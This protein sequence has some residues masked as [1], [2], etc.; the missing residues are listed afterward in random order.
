MG[1][2]GEQRK[3]LDE[4]AARGSRGRVSRPSGRALA[5]VLRTAEECGRC[6]MNRPL[7]PECDDVADEGVVRAPEGL[8]YERLMLCGQSNVE[9]WKRRASLSRPQ[10]CLPGDH[11]AYPS[12]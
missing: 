6:P 5:A 4:L 11:A 8:S 10:A 3:S 9:R 7:E 1:A 2:S 12:R